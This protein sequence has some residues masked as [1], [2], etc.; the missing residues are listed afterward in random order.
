L[1]PSRSGVAFTLN[2]PNPGSDKAGASK[3]PASGPNFRG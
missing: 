1:R 2:F 3:D